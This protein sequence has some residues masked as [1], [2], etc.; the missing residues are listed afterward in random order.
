MPVQSWA[1]SQYWSLVPSTYVPPPNLPVQ[2][3]SGYPLWQ[4][5]VIVGSAFGPLGA[6]AESWWA[7]LK[8]LWRFATRLHRM[9][10]ADRAV[11]E[12]VV[13]MVERQE[14]AVAQSAVKA[15]ATT[16]GFNR[17]DAWLPLHRALKADK[18]ENENRFRHLEACRL[19]RAGA[20]STL[21]NPECHLIV[22]LAYH[23]YTIQP[24]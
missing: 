16:L 17:P 12:R 24:R 20:G 4:G 14:W 21:S 3:Q 15:T 5:G 8:W 19:L 18:R 23:R 2:M 22:E 9:A 13:G 1:H 7:R 11:V 6:L 10:P